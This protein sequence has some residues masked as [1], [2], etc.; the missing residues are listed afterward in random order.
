MEKLKR[1]DKKLAE[2]NAYLPGIDSNS[3]KLKNEMWAG[4]LLDDNHIERMLPEIPSDIKNIKP[5]A[6][7]RSPNRKPMDNYSHY[8]E[9]LH[10]MFAKLLPEEGF[11]RVDPGW[12]WMNLEVGNK[13]D[14][15]SP[16]YVLPTCQYS[17]PNGILVLKIAKFLKVNDK[18]LCPVECKKEIEILSTQKYMI[19]KYFSDAKE[20][21]DVD[22][23]IQYLKDGTDERYLI[24]NLRFGTFGVANYG[25]TGPD[26]DPLES[27]PLKVHDKNRKLTNREIFEKSKT[28]DD[29]QLEVF[30][31]PPEWVLAIKK[32]RFPVVTGTGLNSPARRLHARMLEIERTN[33]D[34]APLRADMSELA[35]NLGFRMEAN[36]PFISK[37]FENKYYEMFP[38]HQRENGFLFDQ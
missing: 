19:E 24:I 22:N 29:T 25:E 38:N 7:S 10:D 4:Y 35:Q 6:I 18:Y 14:G 15:L 27:N 33:N 31:L 17:F 36:D 3:T 26:S 8:E 9:L 28:G 12:K 5:S 20:T 32:T 1:A 13:V 16:F 23:K 37:V 11:L 30:R 21:A 34:D 2:I